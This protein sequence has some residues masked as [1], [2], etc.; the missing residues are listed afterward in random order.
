MRARAQS[1]NKCGQGLRGTVLCYGV[2]AT[3][4]QRR[5][6]SGRNVSATRAVYGPRNLAQK[7]RG[8]LGVLIEAQVRVVWSCRDAGVDGGSGA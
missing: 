5:W 1:R 6:S 2:P 3:V 7:G 8:G 4:E